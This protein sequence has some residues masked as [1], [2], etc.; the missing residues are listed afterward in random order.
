[1]A[2]AAASAV[3]VD[4]P[5]TVAAAEAEADRE[6]ASGTSARSISSAMTSLAKPLGREWGEWMKENGCER[7]GR[8]GK[9]GVGRR[10]ERRF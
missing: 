5:T 1:M 6:A 10:E 3:N 8:V 4:L 7:Q 9:K 2:F